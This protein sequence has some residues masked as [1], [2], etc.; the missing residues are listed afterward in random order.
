MTQSSWAHPDQTLLLSSPETTVSQKKSW[1]KQ[2]MSRQ[3][4]SKS[5]QF[6]DRLLQKSKSYFL[7]T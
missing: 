4:L 1:Q 2:E 6:S 3:Q 7:N 5:S